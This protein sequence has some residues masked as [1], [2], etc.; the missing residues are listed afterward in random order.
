GG[1]SGIGNAAGTFLR[2]VRLRLEG[3]IYDQFDYIVEYDFAHAN[4]EN[5]GIEPPSFG[6]LSSS[7]VPCNVWMQVRDV[8]FF[9]NIRIGN[10]V[11][12]IGF[13]SQMY[14]GFLEF[15][16]RPD[17]NDAFYG[18]FDNGFSLGVTARNHT[19]NERVTWQYGIYRPT[20]NSF[21][22]ALNKFVWGGRVTALPIFEDD[23]RRLGHLGFGTYDGELVQTELRARARP[24]LR[25]GRGFAVPILVDPGDVPG[26]R[27]YTLCPEFAAVLGS[28]TFQ[29]EW[30]GE[31]LT[32]AI[33]P[34]GQNQ[35]T[36]FYHG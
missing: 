7:P 31:Y 8:P 21:G 35:G 9:G 6:N 4:N 11:K 34:N 15:M 26:S 23:G 32:Q 27:R 12:P 3:D 20:I 28:W 22:V 36:V 24:V 19:D 10:Q 17:N 14:Q 29:A 13:T 30:A 33:A 2:R 5:S 18:P 1:T 25:N 16:E